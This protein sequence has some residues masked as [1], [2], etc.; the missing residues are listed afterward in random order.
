MSS[1]LQYMRRL[2]IAKVPGADY[3]FLKTFETKC[4]V[5]LLMLRGS[6]SLLNNSTGS[7]RIGV[8]NPC[9]RYQKLLYK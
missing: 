6:N 3:G 1:V 5:W 2:L 7:F 9:D 4:L 8:T